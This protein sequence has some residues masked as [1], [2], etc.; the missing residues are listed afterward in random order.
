MGHAGGIGR[1]LVQGLGH[2]LVAHAPFA[3]RD[4]GA[5]IFGFQF[6]ERRLV[7]R[8]ASRPMAISS[9]DGPDEGQALSSGEAAGWR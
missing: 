5:L 2:F 1:R 4:D 7:A 9:G 3:A 8:D 6:V